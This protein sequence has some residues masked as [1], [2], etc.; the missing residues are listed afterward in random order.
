MAVIDDCLWFQ[1]GNVQRT[2]SSTRR[3]PDTRQARLVVFVTPSPSNVSTSSC[4]PSTVNLLL[5]V[6]AG[7]SR[8]AMN[9]LRNISETGPTG[10]LSGKGLGGMGGGIVGRGGPAEPV[11]PLPTQSEEKIGVDRLG[12]LAS[13]VEFNPE[14]TMMVRPLLYSLQF[15]TS[16]S[17]LIRAHLHIKAQRNGM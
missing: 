7:P 10:A 17:T 8:K 2:G 1:R 6:C 4:S 16:P 9:Q 15:V 3:S 14:S 13:L 5:T 12:D 11:F